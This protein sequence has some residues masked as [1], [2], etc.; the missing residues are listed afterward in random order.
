MKKLRVV[1]AVTR[2]PRMQGLPPITRG[3]RVIRSKAM[4]PLCYAY[5]IYQR[6]SPAGFPRS[7]SRPR[8]QQG[9]RGPEP[10]KRMFGHRITGSASQMLPVVSSIVK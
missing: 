8:L 3:S 2:S 10:A 6:R 1:R 5:Q 9:G 7:C 4:P